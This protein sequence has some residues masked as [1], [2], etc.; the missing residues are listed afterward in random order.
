MTDRTLGRRNTAPVQGTAA[1]LGPGLDSAALLY[2]PRTRR[3]TPPGRSP[4]LALRCARA[5]LPAS[6]GLVVRNDNRRPKPVTLKAVCG[7]GDDAAPVLAA[8]AVTSE[9]LFLEPSASVEG[10]RE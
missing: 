6:L 8:T 5:P 9:A 4:P 1:R 3:A 10:V 7:P 2:H